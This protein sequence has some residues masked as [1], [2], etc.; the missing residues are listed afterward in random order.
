MALAMG[1]PLAGKRAGGS[2]RAWRAGVRPPP[3]H[4]VTTPAERL[5]DDSM[6]VR[7]V[8]LLHLYVC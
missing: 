5:A 3:P 4:L 1:V 6:S 8:A 2:K 7:C